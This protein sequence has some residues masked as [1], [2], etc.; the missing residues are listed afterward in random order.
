[1]ASNVCWGIEIG[2]GAIKAIKLEMKGDTPRMTDFAYVPH[3]KVLSTPGLDLADAMRVAVGTLTSQVDLSKASIAVS[4]PGNAAFARFTKLPPVEPKKVPDIVTFEA[5]QQIP[6]DLSEVEWDYQTFQSPTSPDI[7]VGIFA[8]AKD[9]IRQ[10]LDLLGDVDL[11]PDVVTLSP[12]AL[13]NALA[14]DL[15]LDETSPGTVIVDVGTNSTDL[16]IAEGGRLWIRTFREASGH[17]FTEALVNRFNLSYPKAERLK[18]EGEASQNAKHVF[19]ALRPVITD[20]AQEI[21]KSIGFYRSN[22]GGANLTRIIGVGNTFNLPGIRKFLKQQVG[23]EVY[24]LQEFKRLQLDKPLEARKEEFDGNALGWATAYGLALQGLGLE[25]V[26]ANLVPTENVRETMW[27]KK[28]PALLTAAGL[29]LLASGAMFFRPYTDSTAAKGLRAPGQ[30]TEAA[31][32]ARELGAQATEAGVVGAVTDDFRA[33]EMLALTEVDGPW[34]FILNDAGQVAEAM[35]QQAQQALARAGR[36][37]FEP[38]FEITQLELDY[39]DRRGDVTAKRQLLDAPAAGVGGRNRARPEGG[40][41]PRGGGSDD[42]F[43]RDRGGGGGRGDDWGEPEA[44][45]PD[46]GLRRI[47]IRA[48]IRTNHPEP[49]QLINGPLLDWLAERAERDG[50]PYVL[51]SAPGTLL[52]QLKEAQSIVADAGDGDENQALADLGDENERIDRLMERELS[53]RTDIIQTGTPESSRRGSLDVASGALA[54]LAP[55]EGP[56]R[57]EAV[58]PESEAELFWYVVIDPIENEGDEEGGDR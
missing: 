56:K 41:T 1:M 45:G 23:I 39:V 6:F 16:I 28:T 17:L 44:E 50:V 18:R 14:Y 21:Q 19:Q 37:Q 5:A 47:A 48:K 33:A 3:A 15:E 38:T 13:F 42:R 9:R 10:Q 52:M 32:R 25:T 22:H 55:I 36:T 7:E 31:N 57:E 51:R 11:R 53:Q 30:I 46:T 4:V 26:D 58:G 29:A 20:L 49:R 34:S 8:I 12:L 27:R 24:K 2:S 40:F 43:E 54:D 35:R